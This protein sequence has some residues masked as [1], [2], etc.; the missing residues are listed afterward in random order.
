MTERLLTLDC[1]YNPAM[2]SE[3]KPAP[4]KV[5]CVINGEQIDREAAPLRDIP[6]QPLA[7]S[8]DR[9]GVPKS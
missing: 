7:P 3:P 9:G 4:R 1:P 5:R 2:A 8:P 6:S